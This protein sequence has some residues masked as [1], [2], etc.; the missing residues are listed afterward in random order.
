MQQQ[1]N[2]SEPTSRLV[3]VLIGSAVVGLIA[4]SHPVLIPPLTVA[5]ATF[6]ALSLVLKL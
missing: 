2:S 1:P 6:M 3:T 5:L 4:V